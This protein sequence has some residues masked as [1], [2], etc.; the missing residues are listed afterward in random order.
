M[1]VAIEIKKVE[2][3]LYVGIRRTMKRD[4]LGPAYAEILSRVTG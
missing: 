4:E 2:P 1:P 3:H